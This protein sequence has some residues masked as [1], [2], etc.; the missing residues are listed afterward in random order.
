MALSKHKRIIIEASILL[1]LVLSF[2][3]II[4]IERVISL[5]Q[6][7]IA[8]IYHHETLLRQY[9]LAS[10]DEQG[11]YYTFDLDEGSL[12]IHAK[13]NAIAIVFSSCPGQDCVHQGYISYAYQTIICAPLGVYI[14][15]SGVSSNEVEVG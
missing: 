1:G 8:S 13:K 12:Q 14:S 7:L 15:I 3:S 9:D 11:E 5:N 2:V 10:L 6:S 4:I